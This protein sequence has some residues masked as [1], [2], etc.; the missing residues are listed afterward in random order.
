MALQDSLEEIYRDHAPA[1][2]RFLIRLTGNET[3]TRDLLQD[4]FIRLAKS[5]RLLDGVAAPRSYLFRLTHRLAIDRHRRDEIRQLYD[6]RA[7]KERE[8]FTSPEPSS[9]DC[10]MA[11]QNSCLLA[12]RA[13]SRAKGCRHPQG[14][15]RK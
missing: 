8:P 2:F 9:E 7:Y 5:P 12:R 6:D 3:E 15:G 4:I 10:R 11:P 14:S 1:L 13:A